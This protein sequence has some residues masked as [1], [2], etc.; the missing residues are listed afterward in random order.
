[1]H[2]FVPKRSQSSRDAPKTIVGHSREGES[3]APKRGGTLAGTKKAKD[4][5]SVRGFDN[6]WERH[7]KS[8]AMH[9]WCEFQ[10]VWVLLSWSL[11]P[12]PREFTGICTLELYFS[13][14]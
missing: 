3:R 2:I 10:W 11:E 6:K 9:L 1:M 4:R 5:S 14:A 12:N 8:D 7:A 13:K